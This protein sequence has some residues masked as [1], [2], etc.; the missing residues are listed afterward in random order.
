M[1]PFVD[2]R[3]ML[4]LLL[5]SLALIA[6]CARVHSRQWGYPN[7]FSR[8]FGTAK[9]SGRVSRARTPQVNL[10]FE[11]DPAPGAARLPAG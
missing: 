11:A 10:R 4:S 7:V 1:A 5:A 8:R 3:R 9:S 2:R 6:G